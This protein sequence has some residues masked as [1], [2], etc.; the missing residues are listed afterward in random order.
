TAEKLLAAGRL[1]AGADQRITALPW[2]ASRWTTSRDVPA[3]PAET[4]RQWWA[5]THDEASR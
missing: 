5:R 4:F 3:P 1:V 2:P